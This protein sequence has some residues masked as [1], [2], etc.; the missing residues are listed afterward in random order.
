MRS[1]R[2]GKSVCVSPFAVPFAVLTG[3]LIVAA[4]IIVAPRQSAPANGSRSLECESLVTSATKDFEV[5]DYVTIRFPCELGMVMNP[6][7]H[8]VIYKTTAKKFTDRVNKM[9]GR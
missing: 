6:R 4:S 3:S 5:S 1:K 8:T 7:A 9:E 2:E